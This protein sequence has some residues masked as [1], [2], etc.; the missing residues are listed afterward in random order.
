MPFCP[1]K[2]SKVHAESQKE[3]FSHNEIGEECIQTCESKKKQIET[4]DKKIWPYV[5]GVR[6]APKEHTLDSSISLAQAFSVAIHAILFDL[7][8]SFCIGVCFM[9]LLLRLQT[10][11]THSYCEQL[12]GSNETVLIRLPLWTIVNECIDVIFIHMVPLVSCLLL[13]Q[14]DSCYT[15]DE[16]KGLFIKFKK[17]VWQWKSSFLTYC[18]FAAMD[19]L[20][21]IILFFVF[22]VP[23]PS[24]YKY[25]IWRRNVVDVIWLLNAFFTTRS[26]CQRWTN[27][28]TEQCNRYKSSL[29]IE[30]IQTEV[31]TIRRAL[32]RKVLLGLSLPVIL[33]IV[34]VGTLRNRSSL[35]LE[36]DRHFA[37][38]LIVALILCPIWFLLDNTARARLPWSNLIK[39]S[40][41]RGSRQFSSTL[42]KR[43]ILMENHD[44]KEAIEEES[45][46]NQN[47]EKPDVVQESQDEEPQSLARKKFCE[48]QQFDIDS[49]D[50]NSFVISS[51]TI[52]TLVIT[53]RMLQANMEHIRLKVLSALITSCLESVVVALEP[54]FFEKG[55]KSK[56]NL[57]KIWAKTK[58][59]LSK[60]K[61]VGVYSHVNLREKPNLELGRVFRWHRAHIIVMV[62]RLELIS[63]WI[64]HSLLLFGLDL[65]N[66]AEANT[67]TCSHEWSVY[68][69]ILSCISLCAIEVFV[70]FWAYVYM[71]KTEKLPI[72][73]A[74]TSKR[75]FFGLLCLLFCSG[76][77]YSNAMS[78]FVIANVSC[79]APNYLVVAQYQCSR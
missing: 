73:Q 56:Q 25:P 71:T 62:N 72:K 42:R 79:D 31:V 45:M 26:V 61:E 23:S 9:V 78:V 68:N 36:Q 63:I 37:L 21:R 34:I 19:V 8:T 35:Y 58:M 69:A 52:C 33:A 74:V 60:V 4:H 48:L 10:F 32:Q 57:N 76:L 51:L 14:Q 20:F 59:R 13:L 38:A 53:V 77:S 39:S 27:A 12:V 1:F 28:L 29:S 16:Q 46:D 2:R 49:F 40:L 50:R 44:L 6:Q 15:K 5:L 70:E 30:K 7:L 24:D 43:E 67:G 18:I 54:Y 65:K 64:S 41:S 11:P 55:H 66:K 17:L 75:M 47:S 3:E 22:V